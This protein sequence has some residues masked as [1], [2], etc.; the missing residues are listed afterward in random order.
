MRRLHAFVGH[1]LTGQK[2][3]SKMVDE[4]ETPTELLPDEPP[5]SGEWVD[6]CDVIV[7]PTEEELAAGEADGET[8][9][10]D[11][12]EDESNG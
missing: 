12:S 7:E 8:V 6:T 9:D 2:R 4:E 1:P 11:G 10:Y 5:S 3:I